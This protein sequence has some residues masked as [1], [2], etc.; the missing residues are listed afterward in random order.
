MSL[1]KALQGQIRR[2]MLGQGQSFSQKRRHSRIVCSIPVQLDADKSTL[3]GK[4][5]DLSLEGARIEVPGDKTRRPKPPLK[6]GQTLVMS[7][8]VANLGR[9]CEGQAVARVRWVRQNQQ[10]GWEVGLSLSQAD[11]NGWVPRLLSECGL[12]PEAFHTRRSQT[13]KPL[14]QKVRVTLGSSQ[15]VSATMTELSM[16]GAAVLSHKALARFLPLRLSFEVAGKPVHIEAQVAHVRS[17]AETTGA[18]ERLWL[19]GLR[20]ESLS[21]EQADLVGRYLLGR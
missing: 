5:M 7:L 2:V 15:V 16:G 8:A 10:G 20:F 17:A 12:G 1:L 18:S 9:S 4:V 6:T 13:R 11:A 3:R 19:C 21:R 14:Q